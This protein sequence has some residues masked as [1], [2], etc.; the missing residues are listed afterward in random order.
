MSIAVFEFIQRDKREISVFSVTYSLGS[1]LTLLEALYLGI[2]LKSC[3]L[4]LFLILKE[5]RLAHKN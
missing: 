5:E 1:P 3:A 2:T 4:S